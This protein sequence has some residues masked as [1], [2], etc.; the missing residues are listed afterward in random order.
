MQ[1]SSTAI[2]DGAPPAQTWPPR[3]DPLDREAIVN[4]RRAAEILALSRSYLKQLRVRGG[5]PRFMHI[6]AQAIRYRTGDLLDWAASKT[7]GSTSEVV[8]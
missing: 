7:V 5:G 3:A 6:A 1:T 8:G 2:S 4:D